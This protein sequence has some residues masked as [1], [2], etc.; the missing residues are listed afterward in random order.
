VQSDYFTCTRFPVP[1]LTTSSSNSSSVSSSSQSSTTTSSSSISTS[2]TT[3]ATPPSYSLQLAQASQNPV[4]ESNLTSPQS[5]QVLQGDGPGD[6][7]PTPCGYEFPYSN[8]ANRWIIEGDVEPGTGSLSANNSGL[9]LT[10]QTCSSPGNPLRVC[11]PYWE[12]NGEPFEENVSQVSAVTNSVP[13]NGQVFSI[14]LSLPQYDFEGCKY[15]ISSTGCSYEGYVPSIIGVWSLDV[16]NTSSSNSYSIAVS[17]AESCS[18][19][20]APYSTCI[21]STNQL[22]VGISTAAFVNGK[23]DSGLSVNLTP[24]VPY[25]SYSENHELTIATDLHSYFEVWVDNILEYSSSTVPI[26]SGNTYGLNFY[27][28]D[29]VDNMTL[30]TIWK[31]MTVHSSPYISVTG[32]SSGMTVVATGANGFNSTATPNSNG[33]ANLDASNQPSNLSISVELNGQII[34]TYSSQVSI[35]TELKLVTT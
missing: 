16:G 22:S 32:L 7:S 8:G 30:S 20:A 26:P 6:C 34:A 29:N 25:M 13:T 1:T 24:K 9:T 19:L 31:N 17:L 2:N 5:T 3:T 12:W 27:Q 21:S 23:Y 4:L 10:D 18:L 15:N 33:I 28:F 11:G 35:G 14:Y